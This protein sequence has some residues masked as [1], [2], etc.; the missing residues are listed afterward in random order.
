MLIAIKDIGGIANVLFTAVDARMVYGWKGIQETTQSLRGTDASEKVMADLVVDVPDALLDL[1]S[2][3]ELIVAK[4]PPPLPEVTPE[5]LA[6]N[7]GSV[8]EISEGMASS[9]LAQLPPVRRPVWV[10]HGWNVYDL[11][12][13]SFNRKLHKKFCSQGYSALG[14]R[15][16][17]P[18]GAYRE[19]QRANDPDR[20]VFQAARAGVLSPCSGRVGTEQEAGQ[21]SCWGRPGRARRKQVAIKTP[22]H[23]AG[24]HQVIIASQTL[25]ALVV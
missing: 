7:D 13:K 25:P 1:I 8:M 2:R 21:K 14:V 5:Q 9:N 16:R 6:L 11:T 20:A 10:G 23:V 19:L 12:G 24:I 17:Q 22:G 15:R 3:R 18:A 4:T